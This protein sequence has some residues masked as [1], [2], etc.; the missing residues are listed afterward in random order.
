MS[1]TDYA[2]QLSHPHTSAHT[3][4]YLLK[5]KN[6]KNLQIPSHKNSNRLLSRHKQHHYAK[7]SMQ[8]LALQFDL[9]STTHSPTINTAIVAKTRR[10]PT[11]YDF[12]PMGPTCPPPAFL[13]MDFLGCVTWTHRSTTIRTRRKHNLSQNELVQPELSPKNRPKSIN[14]FA[15][16]LD[17]F[18]HWLFFFVREM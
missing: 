3:H 1:H 15:R 10:F 5:R 6:G 7:L 13:Y 14:S 17:R 12:D 11:F 9:N 2:A 18:S 4:G 16:I 8:R